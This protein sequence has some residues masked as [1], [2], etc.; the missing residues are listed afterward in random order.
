M[1]SERCGQ[2]KDPARTL[3]TSDLEQVI[4]LERH[5]AGVHPTADTAV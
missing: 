1:P 2:R 4:A 3:H 5:M